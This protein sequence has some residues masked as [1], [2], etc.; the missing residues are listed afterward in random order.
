MARLSAAARPAGHQAL[1]RLACINNILDQQDMFAF[2]PGFR[3]VQQPDLP[4]E[5]LPL[6]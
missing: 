5:T 4:L 6:P 3:V 2:Q 1:E